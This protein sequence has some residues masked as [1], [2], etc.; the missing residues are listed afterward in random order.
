M[1]GE[2]QSA[3]RGHWGVGGAAAVPL[4]HSAPHCHSRA[5]YALRKWG[6]TCAV[7]AEWGCSTSVLR[8][9]DGLFAGGGCS[10]SRA[11]PEQLSLGRSR[12]VAKDVTPPC[13]P[14][15]PPARGTAPFGSVAGAG[16]EGTAP[17]C[18]LTGTHGS[19]C[20]SPHGEHLGFTVKLLVAFSLNCTRVLSH[21]LPC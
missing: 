12:A 2:G 7:Q 21:C 11:E 3:G 17:C 10:G 6:G 20:A 15:R 8:G 18:S 1:W 14:P 4:A 19:C 16:R 5:C 13:S 9:S